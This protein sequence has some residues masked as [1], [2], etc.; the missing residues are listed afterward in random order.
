MDFLKKI[1]NILRYMWHKKYIKSF[2]IIAI[3][4]LFLLKQCNQI[5]NLKRDITQVELDATRNFNNYKAAQDSVRILELDNGKKASTIKSYEFD[6]SNLK[7]RQ[8]ELIDKYDDVLDINKDL[9]KVNSLLSVKLE[10]KDSIL[11]SISV[12]RVDSTTDMIRFNKFDNFGNGNTRTLNGSMFVYKNKD[13]LLYRD[14]NFL[15]QQEMSLYTSIEELD[16]QKS[17][18]IT[19]DYPGLIIT[20]IEN[21][22]LIN[23]KLNQNTEKNSGWGI[24]FGIGYGVNLN[25]NQIISY[26]PNIGIGLYWS[27]KWLRF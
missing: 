26:G 27:P 2:F 24:G 19:T 6:V 16:G 8:K 22:N 1:L 5:S 21:I 18:K 9:N 14:A 20:D 17:V 7:D 23:T 4:A 15:I 25:N 3:L 13:S 12:E 11:T 10:V